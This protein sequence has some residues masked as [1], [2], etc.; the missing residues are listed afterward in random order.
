MSDASSRD[1]RDARGTRDGA[2]AGVTIVADGREARVPSDITVAAAL[3]NL[4][5]RAF[6]RS[7]TRGEPRAPLCGMGVCYECR[8]CVD[9]VE[10]RRSCM[11]PVADGQVVWTGHGVGSGGSQRPRDVSGGRSRPATPDPRPPAFDIVVIGAGPAGIA[12]ATR[13]AESGRRVVVL[14][15]SPEVGGQIYVSVRNDTTA[16][17]GSPA[18]RDSMNSTARPPRPPAAPA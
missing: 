14:D 17:I 13:A 12:A 5:V 9:G 11:I 8:V 4:G 15:E 16:R 1:A 10:Q 3:T 18:A 6:R 2:P 7:A